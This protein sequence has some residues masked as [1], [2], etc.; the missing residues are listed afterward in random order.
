[1]YLYIYFYTSILPYFYTSI[2]YQRSLIP[3]E[4]HA[5]HVTH[6]GITLKNINTYIKSSGSL[7][8][9]QGKRN[10]ENPTK[11]TEFSNVMRNLIIKETC[12]PKS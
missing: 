9:H 11:I 10:K 6:P 12:V 5:L 2:L 3:T 8:F 1:M 7:N 4:S